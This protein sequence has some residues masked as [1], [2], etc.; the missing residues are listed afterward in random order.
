VARKGEDRRSYS[1]PSASGD[2][3]SAHLW[4]DP[5][6]GVEDANSPRTFSDLVEPSP[7]RV[8]L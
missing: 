1:L 8:D 2:H 5:L 6:S 4:T 7:N 3:V